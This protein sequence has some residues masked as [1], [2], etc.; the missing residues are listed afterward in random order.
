MGLAVPE[1][2]HGAGDAQ[3]APVG[4][5]IPT[6]VPVAL[7][8][9]DLQALFQAGRWDVLTIHSG[10]SALH[11]ILDANDHG[12]H[13]DLLGDLVQGTLEGESRLHRAMAAL[14]ST[15]GLVGVEASGTEVIAPML[16]GPVSSRPA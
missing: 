12:V 11:G 16:M 9:N 3:A 2:A 8:A 1:M 13:P 14:G 7:S 6:V 5:L 4:H 10:L 15:T